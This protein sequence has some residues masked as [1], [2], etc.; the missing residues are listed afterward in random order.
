MLLRESLTGLSDVYNSLVLSLRV[1][2]LFG[3]RSDCGDTS[4]YMQEQRMR[5]GPHPEVRSNAQASDIGLAKPMQLIGSVEEGLSKEKGPACKLTC[6]NS[7][8]I[9]DFHLIGH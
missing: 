1:L 2:L 4:L 3:D 8:G 6:H 7:W 5:H 9:D